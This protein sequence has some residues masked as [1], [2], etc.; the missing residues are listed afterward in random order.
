MARTWLKITDLSK[1]ITDSVLYLSKFQWH[2]YR[3]R[4]NN[5]KMCMKPKQTLNS[6]SNLQKE[7][8]ARG[9]MLLDFKIHYKAIVIKKVQ[10][11]HKTNETK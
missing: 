3:N 1:T 2:F 7:N 10:Y 8:K 9:I 11:R 4:I 5:P 6:Q